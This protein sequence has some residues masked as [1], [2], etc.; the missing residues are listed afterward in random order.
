MGACKNGC[1]RCGVVLLEENL[2]PESLERKGWSN[3][4]VTTISSLTRS[5]GSLVHCFRCGGA[6]QVCGGGSVKRG[7]GCLSTCH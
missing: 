5:K 3:S 6:A 4:C 7:I 2:V 1:F